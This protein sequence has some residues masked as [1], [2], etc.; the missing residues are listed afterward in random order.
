MTNFATRIATAATI[1]AAA[2]S[3]AAASASAGA[4]T[5]AKFKAGPWKAAAY[6]DRNSGSFSH[7]AAE[8]TYKSGITLVFSVTSKRQ[9]YMGFAHKNWDLSRGNKYPV[10][11]QVDS[12]EVLKSTAVVKTSKVVEVFLP[13]RDSLFRHFRMGSQ[14]KVLAGKKRMTFNLT[15]TDT[16][17]SKLY[18]CATHYA[19]RQES[20]PFATSSNDPFEAKPKRDPFAGQPQAKAQGQP[21]SGPT[22]F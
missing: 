5:I 11:F 13:P 16:M 12:G 6:S 4:N 7:C 14:L 17:L 21:V 20:D 19:K 22:F 15:A 3:F 9:W 10:R 1:F 2:V 18:R 8:G